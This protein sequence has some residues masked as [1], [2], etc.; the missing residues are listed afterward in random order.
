[1]VLVTGCGKSSDATSADADEVVAGSSSPSRS[2]NPDPA[3]PATGDGAGAAF[4]VDKV[5]WPGDLAGAAAL[6]DQMPS[7]L[8]GA[9]LRRPRFF[10]GAAG[11]QYGRGN[12]A[13]TAWVMEPSRGVRGA[14]SALAVMFGLTMTCDKDSYTGTI[15]Q[16][17][18]GTPDMDRS[19]SYDPDG[20]PPWWFACTVDGAEGD[21]KFTGYALGWA[22]GNLGWLT[23]TEDRASTRILTDALLQARAG[24]LR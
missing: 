9:E 12:S 2:P 8:T 1:M 6:F 18:W 21:P 17:R 3:E 11:V 14:P 4:G 7:T 13:P 10:G 23:V 24:A 19:D 22:S 20:D 16:T 5:T 15:P